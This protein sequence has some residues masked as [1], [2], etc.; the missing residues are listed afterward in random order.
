MGASRSSP[1]IANS[2]IGLHP[3]TLCADLTDGCDFPLYR[4][5]IN[6]HSRRRYIPLFAQ[7]E[8]TTPR[9]HRTAEQHHC[10]FAGADV[11][12]TGCRRWD[13]ARLAPP[14]RRQRW[15]LTALTS[16]YRMA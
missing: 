9:P 2:S 5:D 11:A 3:L 12:G 16:R 6:M 13:E 8:A 14:R 15:A 1:R 4:S 7:V 10:P